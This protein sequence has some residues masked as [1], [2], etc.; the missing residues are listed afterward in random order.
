MIG[1]QGV[2]TNAG[3]AQIRGFEFELTSFLNENWSVNAGFTLLD[4]KYGSFLNT[5]TLRRELGLLENK[6]NPLSY[7]PDESFNLGLSYN[8]PV[9]FG[10]DVTLSVDVSYRS[11]VYYREFN[12]KKDSTDPYTIVNLNVNWQSADDAMRRDCLFV[13]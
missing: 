3:D 10:G 5:D 13:T 8:T 2:I 4:S 9:G 12:Q 1:F 11:R 7:A 6:G